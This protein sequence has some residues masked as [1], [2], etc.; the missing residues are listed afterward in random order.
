MGCFGPWCMVR[1][2]VDNMPEMTFFFLELLEN[3]KAETFSNVT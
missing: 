1:L 2:I 3:K